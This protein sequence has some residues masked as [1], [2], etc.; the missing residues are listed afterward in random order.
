MGFFDRHKPADSGNK[1]ADE[2]SEA[3][4][5]A[6][7]ERLG[8]SID[9]RIKPL[10]EGFEKLQSDWDT[11]KTEATKAPTTTTQ[12][13][14]ADGTPRELTDEEKRNNATRATVSLAVQT[15]ARLTER[16]VLDEI[17]SAWTHLVP[18]IREYFNSTPI[19]RK[20]QADYADYCRNI[21]DMVIG[22]AAKEAGLR[23]DGQNKTFFLE[24]KSTSVTREDGPLS[25]PALEWQQQKSDGSIKRWSVADQLR[26]LD[27][28]PT[29]FSENVKKGIV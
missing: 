22:K 1:T 2:Q 3:Q 27:I 23:Y 19:E 7:V 13:T 24:D 14:N 11:I 4:M 8:A 15:N 9:E 10:R 21:V 5:N 12:A 26:A 29:K 25:D 6:L 17:N 20:A 18:K 28:D 16:E